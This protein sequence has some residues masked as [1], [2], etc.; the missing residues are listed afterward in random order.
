[1]RDVQ[2]GV[3]LA[4]PG[5]P[6]EWLA[7]GAAFEAAGVDA[8]WLDHGPAPE[9]DPLVL[10]AALAALTYR[11]RLV[12]A[13]PDGRAQALATLDR[14]SR[15]RLAL[16]SGDGPVLR[17]GEGAYADGDGR[18]WVPAEVP[19]GRTAWR[20][21]L[22]E[23]GERGDYGVLV[24]ADPRLLDLLRNPDDPGGREDLQLAQG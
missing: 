20:E 24:P 5:E 19:L 18:R 13:V 17:L 6:G 1:M 9:L 16:I 11:A 21:L 22:R 4:P 15:G 7:E 12:A 3:V 2:V 14:V 8:L 10:A 23:R